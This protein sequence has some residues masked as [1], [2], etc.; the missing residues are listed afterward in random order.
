MTGGGAPFVGR[1]I[2]RVE[3]DRLLRG[4]GRYVDDLQ[5]SEVLEVAFV[6]STHA[7]ALIK[8]VDVAKAASSPGVRAVYTGAD[9]AGRLGPLVNTEEMRVP[10]LVEE[11]LHPLV[12]VQ[13]MPL[14]ADGEVSFVGQPV[15]MIVAANRYLAEDAAE[16]VEV[17]YE[18]LPAVVDPE[19]ALLDG[20][21]LVVQGEA[22]N[23]AIR[24][25]QATGD[26]ESAFAAA[27]VVVEETYASQRYVA[28]PIETR[29]LVAQPEPFRGG[30]TVWSSTQTPHRMRDHLARSLDLDPDAVR[31]V[32]VDVGG[33]FGQKGVLYVEEILVPYAA[34]D[35][36]ATVRWTEDRQENLTS[37]SHAREQVHHI[38]VAADEDG[39]LLA[40]RDH[41]T[42]NLGCRNMTGLVVPYN[43]VCHLLGPYQVPSAEIEGVGALTNTTFTTPYRGAGRPEAVFA[44]ERILDRLADR[45]GIDPF[46]LRARNLVPAEAMP[47]R[48][49]LLDRWGRPQEYDSGDYPYMLRRAAE[50]IGLDQ[51]RAEQLD[52]RAE[53]CYLG[54]GVSFYIEATGLG[55]FESATVTVLP[56]GRVRVATGAPSQGQG[57]QTTF[58]QIAADALGVRMRDITVVGGDTSQVPFGVGTIASRALVTAGNAIALAAGLVRQKLLDATAEVL[59]VDPA[60]LEL[61]A[62]RLQV[63]GQPDRALTLAE[64][65][66]AMVA[67]PSAPEAAS[68]SETAYFRAPGFA[69][70]SGVNVVKVEVEPATGEV[71]ILDH[72][73]VHD[74][75]MVVNPV[76]AQGQIRGGVAQGIGGALFEE[77]VYD[78]SGQPRTT[79]YLDYLLPTADTVPDIRIEEMSTATPT[80]PLGVKGLG[81]G[82]AIGP[83]AAIANAV[84]DA[85]RPLGVIV[86]RGPLSPARLRAL[87]RAG[88]S[89]PAA[90]PRNRA[91]TS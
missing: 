72:L 31:V 50:A 1:S 25:R 40:L 11:Q 62:G 74:A 54:I 46:E 7:H 71:A 20:A 76:I 4:G 44:M 48:T 66:R 64:L 12:K 58:A 67:A 9:I 70:A 39:R 61:A 32:S 83:P 23:V 86:R 79:T 65:S 3:D 51:F 81:E 18:P 26:V 43:T 22:D 55:P 68:L 5:F 52:A 57:H 19:A 89:P 34:D 53:G 30:M 59:E 49:G 15:A 82:G 60:D 75:G 10:P 6:R 42:V 33:G 41:F 80:N 85:L 2:P 37:S 28:S 17:D 36:G 73:V 29:G 91:K 78:E 13:P 35:L 87:L 8:V 84:E 88:Q 27:P 16:A 45:L 14:L 38:A 24:V 21:P 69:V 63:R 47:Y 90:A 77:M 56:T